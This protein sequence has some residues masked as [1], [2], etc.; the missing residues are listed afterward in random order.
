MNLV[1]ISKQSPFLLSEVGPHLIETQKLDPKDDFN[2]GVLQYNTQQDLFEAEIG[3]HKKELIEKL[4]C[5]GLI[6][7]IEEPIIELPNPIDIKVTQA[8]LR[9]ALEGLEVM[10]Q[11]G[12]NY[13]GY[14]QFPTDKTYTWLEIPVDVN[15]RYNNEESAKSR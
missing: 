15:A 8:N 1:L 13:V 14:K 5:N 4:S 6:V 2:F 9:F 3:Q 12:V 11:I 7:L 10:F